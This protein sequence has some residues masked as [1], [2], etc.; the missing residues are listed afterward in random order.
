[1]AKRKPLPARPAREA[2]AEVDTVRR[3]VQVPRACLPDALTLSWP[4]L[5]SH[6][7]SVGW[8]VKNTAAFSWCAKDHAL[9]R[10][11]RDELKGIPMLF[12]QNW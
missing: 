7:P 10:E 2:G 5:E 11:G 12:Y 9:L 1:M 3:V 6:A 8:V 4:E